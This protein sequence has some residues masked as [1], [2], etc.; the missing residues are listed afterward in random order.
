MNGKVLRICFY[1]YFII[2]VVLFRYPREPDHLPLGD[3]HLATRAHDADSHDLTNLR[4]IVGYVA[5]TKDLQL[6]LRP[7]KLELVCWPNASNGLH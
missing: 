3:S 7:E 2:N 1:Y 5:S 4:R 6:E